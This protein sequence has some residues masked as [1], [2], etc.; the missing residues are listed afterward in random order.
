LAE[1]RRGISSL[2]HEARNYLT[3]QQRA[4]TA[5]LLK[6]LEKLIKNAIR[7]IVAIIAIVLISIIPNRNY[8]G[9]RKQRLRSEKHQE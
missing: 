1:E 4:A 7:R 3:Q 6:I 8:I 2:K 9:Q 5:G